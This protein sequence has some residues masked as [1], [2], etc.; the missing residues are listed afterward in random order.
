MLSK[1]LNYFKLFCHLVLY[2]CRF[3]IIVF[4]KLVETL[5]C[6]WISRSPIVRT[7]PEFGETGR[8]DDL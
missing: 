5:S 2:L 1:M 3:A 8:G 6:L 7:A 4:C